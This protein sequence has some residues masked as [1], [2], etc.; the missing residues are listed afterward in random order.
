MG[1]GEGL[2]PPVRGDSPCAICLRVFTADDAVALITLESRVTHRQYFGVHASC[3][4]DVLHPELRR[5][6][7]AA[8]VPPGLA[9]LRPAPA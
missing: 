7:D 4:R 8:D 9:I 2:R 5:F 3:L 6:L 1:D